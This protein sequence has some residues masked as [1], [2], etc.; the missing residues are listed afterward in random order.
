MRD[1]PKDILI[2]QAISA[3]R[4]RSASGR[5]LA[6]PAWWDLAPEGREEL[7][8]SQLESRRIERALHPTGLSATAR[9][10]LDRLNR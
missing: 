8:D 9:A 3:Y 1:N 6:S 10:V 2:E 5:I 4:E 7:F